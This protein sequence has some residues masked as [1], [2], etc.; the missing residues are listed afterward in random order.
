M[1]YDRPKAYNSEFLFGIINYPKELGSM[2]AARVFAIE[3]MKVALDA[4]RNKDP[5]EAELVLLATINVLS[6]P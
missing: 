1:A 6:K 3:K 4:I 2:E 5:K